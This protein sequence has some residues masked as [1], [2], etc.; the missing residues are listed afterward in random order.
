MDWRTFIFGMTK[1]P[2]WPLVGLVCLWLGWLARRQ[3]AE[4]LASLSKV[5]LPGGFGLELREKL[6]QIKVTA[7]EAEEEFKETVKEARNEAA[8][9]E[10]Q[11]RDEPAMPVVV[12][13]RQA[14]N[15]EWRI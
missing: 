1:A 11:Q 14:A 15:P 10:Q 2:A 9:I 8:S 13:R 5:T 6:A 3:I 4:V 12:W 7:K